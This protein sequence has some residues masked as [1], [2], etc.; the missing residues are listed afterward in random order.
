MCK[1]ESCGHLVCNFCNLTPICG[2]CEEKN[3]KPIQGEQ[4]KS[5]HIFIDSEW[6]K[7]YIGNLPFATTSEELRQMFA[8][9][10][11]IQS[12]S[13]HPFKDF[14]NVERSYGFVEFSNSKSARKVKLFEIYQ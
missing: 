5:Q 11:E 12:V 6:N 13:V 7:V 8:I 9:C 10:G 2:I 14:K 1:K 3:K 4:K